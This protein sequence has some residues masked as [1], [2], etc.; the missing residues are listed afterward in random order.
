[1]PL[2]QHQLSV[3]TAAVWT[4]SPQPFLDEETSRAYTDLANSVSRADLLRHRYNFRLQDAASTPV[5]WRPFGKVAWADIEPE[6][7]PWL[8]HGSRREYGHW[9][10]WIKVGESIIRMFNLDSDRRQADMLQPF[11]NGWT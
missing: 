10:W 7:W 11:P 2:W 8:Q 5:S 3:I 6:L 1:M 9:I 4:G